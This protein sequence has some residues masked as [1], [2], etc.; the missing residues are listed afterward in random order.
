M[1]LVDAN[2]LVYAYSESFH[3]H[4]RAREWLD[5][6]LNGDVPLGLPWP[7]LLAFVRLVSNPR[8]FDRPVSVHTAWKQV[9]E[10]LACRPVWIPHP[11]DRHAAI[12]GRLLAGTGM[13]ASCVPDAHLAALALEHGLAVVSADTDFSRFAG[14]RLENPLA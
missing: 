8:V 9:E 14:I 5:Q 10:W 13:R 12:L 4:E 11:T 3:Q 6:Q 1:R 2:I 7:S